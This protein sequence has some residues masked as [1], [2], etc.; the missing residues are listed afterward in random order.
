MKLHLKRVAGIASLNVD[1]METLL[2]Q[3]ESVL[4]S[5]PLIPISSDPN[6]NSCLTPA[7]FM[8]GDSLTAPVEPTLLDVNENR[9]LRD[10]QRVKQLQQHFW[11]RWSN[12]YLN[13]LQQRTKWKY[14]STS[15]KPGQ[16]VI[17]REDN[18]PPLCWPLARIKEVHPGS[19][20]VVR[21]ATVTISKGSYK[22]PTTRLCP[23][24]LDNDTVH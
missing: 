6:D 13:E 10:R 2:A 17:L 3:I 7:H 9:L 24:P 5:C 21:A 19:D 12:D 20:G 15:L 16:L 1:E 14:G 8:I 23:L 11:K 22:R 4:N 18:T